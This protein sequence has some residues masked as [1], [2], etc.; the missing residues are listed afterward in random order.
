MMGYCFSE[1]NGLMNLIVANEPWLSSILKVK[2]VDI[3]EFAPMT[4][5]VNEERMEFYV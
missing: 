4:Y 3:N 1:L 5:F 2:N